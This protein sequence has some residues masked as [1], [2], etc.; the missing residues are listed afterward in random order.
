[1]KKHLLFIVGFFLLTIISCSKE[2]SS[3]ILLSE[4]ENVVKQTLISFN[5][6]AVKTK[7]YKVFINELS[8][9]S[10]ISDLTPEELDLLVDEFLKEQTQ[11][12]QQLY[13]KLAELNLTSEEFSIIASEFDYLR[14]DNNFKLNKGRICCEISGGL[15][16]N[17]NPLGSVFKW[18]CGC[19][20]SQAAS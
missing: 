15:E 9:K 5:N 8:R 18:A 2:E 11:E 17:G 19:E 6:S 14:I 1:M 20:E 12:F 4:K 3:E 16:S 10:N 13:Y 7:K